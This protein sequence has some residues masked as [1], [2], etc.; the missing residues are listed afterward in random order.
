MVNELVTHLT[1]ASAPVPSVEAILHAVIPYKYVDHT[2]ADAVVAI[3]NSVN[4][5]DILRQLY[6]D[7]V[8]YVPYVMPGFDLS[9]LCAKQLKE[10]LTPDK[11]GI[12]LLHH[13]IFSFGDTAEESYE[14]MIRLVKR[15]EDYLSRTA[16]PGEPLTK[17]GSLK[18][19]RKLLRHCVKIFPALPV[20]PLFS[21]V[22]P[23]RKQ[24]D[25]VIVRILMPYRNRGLP[26]PTM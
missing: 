4:G 12:I 2:H 7:D 6:G 25:S 20:F 11:I 3:S 14:R 26:H 22:F 18:T 13:G 5:D 10:E 1:K 24:W 23:M 21:S 19:K 8:I 15:A 16:V 9:K 17:S